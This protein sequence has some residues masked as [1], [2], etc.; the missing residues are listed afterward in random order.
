MVATAAAAR[1][2][3]ANPPGNQTPRLLRQ[4]LVFRYVDDSN[5]TVLASYFPAEDID[6]SL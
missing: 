4:I 2:R 6:A 5:P 1:P 3:P